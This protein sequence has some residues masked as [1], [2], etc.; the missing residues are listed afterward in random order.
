MYN[1][2]EGQGAQAVAAG[3]AAL[4]HGEAHCALVGGCDVKT[5][6]LGSIALEQQGVFRSWRQHGAGCIPGEGAAFLVLEDETVAR[7]RS[8]RVYARLRDC[9]V[10]TVAVHATRSR[11][12][13]DALRPLVQAGSCVCV[14]AGDGDTALADAETDALRGLECSVTVVA[15]PKAQL[16]NLFAAAAALQVGL[17][18]ALIRDGRVGSRVVANCFGYGSAQAAFLL[19]RS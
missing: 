2:W 7:T 4:R 17:G 18:A 6:E 13:A 16:G 5:H 3:S 1:P 11:V 9:V 19:E 15:R 10:K 14:S 12:Y 8:A